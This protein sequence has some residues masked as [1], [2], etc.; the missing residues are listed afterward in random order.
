MWRT[1]VDIVL[2]PRKLENLQN[3]A[4]EKTFVYSQPQPV[5]L[6]S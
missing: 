5:P 1:A 4:A 6:S 3:V 2:L